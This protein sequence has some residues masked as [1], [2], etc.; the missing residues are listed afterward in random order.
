MYQFNVPEIPSGATN[1]SVSCIAKVQHTRSTASGEVQLYSGNT[2]KGS[3]STFGN[4]ATTVDLTTGT[5]TASELGDVRIRIGNN[6]NGGTTTYYTRFYG[7]TLTVSYTIVEDVYIYTISNIS[8]NHT[9][10]IA[11]ASSSS[12]PYFLKVNNEFRQVNK[13]YRKV[14]NVWVEISVEDLADV[15]GPYFYKGHTVMTGSVSRSDTTTS[16]VINDGALPAGNYTLRYED[17]NGS[18][19]SNI[20]EIANITIS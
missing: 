18:I 9:I 17:S 10:A 7:A 16:I 11:D 13:I 5:W 2:A 12:I 8:T 3:V 1:I 15:Q 4:T 6:Y 19:I 20:D 14:N